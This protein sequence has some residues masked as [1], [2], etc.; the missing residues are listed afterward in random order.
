[1]TLE[2]I[3]AS[4]ESFRYQLLDRM[5]MDC[6]Y[7]LGYGGRHEKYLWCGNVAKQIDYMKA[8]WNSFKEKPVWLTMEQIGKYEQEMK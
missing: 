5:K 7:Y 1:M 8:I 4:E 3:L 2:S 6:E